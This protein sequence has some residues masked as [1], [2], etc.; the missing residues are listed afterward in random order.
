MKNP[1]S[2]EIVDICDFIWMQN[3]S[4]FVYFC[5]SVNVL[6]SIVCRFASI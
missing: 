6:T 2:N 1:Q 4:Y 5:L 3:S